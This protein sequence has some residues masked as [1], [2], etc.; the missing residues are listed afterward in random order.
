MNRTYSMAAFVNALPL[1]SGVDY[2]RVT[3]SLFACLALAVAAAFLLRRLGGYRRT[4]TQLR[5]LEVLESI[6]LDARTSLHLVRC[7]EGRTLVA[8]SPGAIALASISDKELPPT[9]V[10]GGSHE[11]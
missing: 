11:E 5:Q 6:R 9:P 10:S 2:M 4:P 1:D 8:C 7:G 3:L